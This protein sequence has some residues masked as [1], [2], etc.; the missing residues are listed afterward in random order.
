MKVINMNE[1]IS[2]TRCVYYESHLSAWS[3]KL[4]NTKEASSINYLFFSIKI[5]DSGWG[6]TIA[7]QLMYCQYN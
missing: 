3:E 5:I 1:N 6:G 4:L 7:H 2:Y